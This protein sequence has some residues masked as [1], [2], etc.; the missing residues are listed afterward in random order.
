MLSG[1]DHLF[2][3][4]ADCIL[5]KQLVQPCWLGPPE[6]PGDRKYALGT[7]RMDV[8]PF[9]VIFCPSS[10]QQ[11]PADIEQKLTQFRRAF[12]KLSIVPEEMI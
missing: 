11:V 6:H 1:Y 3:G 7:A 10:G 8:L 9:A 12:V 5:S 4:A 2:L